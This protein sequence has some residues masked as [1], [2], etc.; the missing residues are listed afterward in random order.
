MKNKQHYIERIDKFNKI[1]KFPWREDQK[2]I[3][4][5]II[6]NKEKY[7]V[8]NGIF[9]CGKTTLLFGALINLIIRKTISPEDVM[10]ISFNVCIRNEI[11][12]KLKPFGFKGKIRATTF[13]SIIY[14]I[15]KLYK[16][17]YLDLPNF[18]GKKKILLRKM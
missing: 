5:K 16:Y 10:F 8:I 4:K 3:I 15:C 12:R 2:E 7:Y 6:E 1:V 11:K 17:P 14:Q 18:D 9:G 13:D